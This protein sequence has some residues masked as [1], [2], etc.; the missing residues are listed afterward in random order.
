MLLPLEPWCSPA[1]I[2]FGYGLSASLAIARSRGFSMTLHVRSTLPS[3]PSLLPRR[4]WRKSEHCPQ[5][6]R[7]Q[8]T[9]WPVWVG[10]PEHHRARLGSMS[11]CAILHHKPYKVS[12]ACACSPPGRKVLNGGDEETCGNVTRLVPTQPGFQ[13]RLT[14]SVRCYN[15]LSPSSL[16]RCRVGFCRN[17]AMCYC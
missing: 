8:I 1:H 6:F 9:P 13:P 10:T 7:P 15:R 12:Q 3:F 17:R 4:G 16:G 11:P 5:S 2:P 14:P